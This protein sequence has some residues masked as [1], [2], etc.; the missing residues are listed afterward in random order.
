MVCSSTAIKKQFLKLGQPV[1]LHAA[2]LSPCFNASLFRGV[3]VCFVESK[4][5]SKGL[6]SGF[7]FL[8]IGIS[9]RCLAEQW[10][11]LLGGGREAGR[12]I[13]AS[14][15]RKKRATAKETHK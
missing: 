15:Q 14:N 3:C 5:E 8:L 11:A 1:V 13:L 10:Q 6:D 7:A 4:R 9:S 12:M 2:F